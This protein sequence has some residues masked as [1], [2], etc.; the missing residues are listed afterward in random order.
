[1]WRDSKWA[2]RGGNV[3]FDYDAMKGRLFDCCWIGWVGWKLYIYRPC[4]FFLYRTGLGIL[5][6]FVNGMWE[7][8]LYFGWADVLFEI[9]GLEMKTSFHWME[10]YIYTF[11]DEDS[12]T[13]GVE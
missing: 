8:A 9:I 12:R 6:A 11:S 2:R 1:M 4:G 3:L 13:R 7:D 10:K 5:Q